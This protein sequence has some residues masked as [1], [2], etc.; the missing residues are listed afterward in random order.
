MAK[1]LK[2]LMK[3]RLISFFLIFIVFLNIAIEGKQDAE[4]QV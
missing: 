3:C 1:L 4:T 2:S